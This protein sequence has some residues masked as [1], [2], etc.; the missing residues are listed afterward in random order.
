MAKQVGLIMSAPDVF[1]WSPYI[2]IALGSLAGLGALRS[3]NSAGLFFGLA[4]LLQCL[5]WPIVFV[6]AEV[7]EKGWTQHWQVSLDTGFLWALLVVFPYTIIGAVPVA[8]LIG[9]V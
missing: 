6:V 7:L 4:L 5:A 1:A 9:L 8:F 3:W 2:A